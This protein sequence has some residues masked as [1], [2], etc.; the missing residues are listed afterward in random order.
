MTRK[1]L[2]VLAT[3]VGA[4]AVVPTAQ[5]A[6]SPPVWQCR[7]SSLYASVSGQN[8]VEPIVANGNINTANGVS[9]DL[10]LCA[11]SE[12]GAGNTATQLG[13]PPNVIG[14]VTGKAKT[15]IDPDI[16]NVDRPGHRR[17]GARRGSHAARPGRPAGDRRRR[18]ELDRHGEVHRG[19]HRADVHG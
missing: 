16:G 12:T 6:T 9:P 3:V 10:T 13:I 8:R 2:V 18:G 14:A 1:P 5:A 17:R 7:A 4:L 11:D 15:A 19:Q